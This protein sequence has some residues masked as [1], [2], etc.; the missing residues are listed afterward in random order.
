LQQNKNNHTMKKHA[1]LLIAGS[2]MLMTACNNST[3]QKPAEN[4]DSLANV[5]AEQMKA[6]MAAKNDSVINAMAK[7]KADSTEAANKKEEEMK[8]EEE[9]KKASHTKGHTK[10][11]KKDTKK[12]T[13]A[14]APT[15]Q[16]TKFN[17][18]ANNNLQLI[19]KLRMTS[20]TTEVNKFN[21]IK[22][23]KKA[24]IIGAFLLKEI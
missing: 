19:K 9:A 20:S 6:E 23:N 21:F 5:K 22:T 4:V 11:T 18:R 1:L 15:T 16:D 2:V 7:A 10:D 13:A 17:D 24:P 8:K 12:T 14:P 3:E